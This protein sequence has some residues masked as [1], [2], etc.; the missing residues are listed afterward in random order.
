MNKKY[1]AYA[2]ISII[3]LVFLG[4]CS[5]RGV[6]MNEKLI[7][8]HVIAN[9]DSK[10]DQELKLK[11]R[12]AVLKEIGPKLESS[13]NKEES[14]KILNDNL[15]L[16]KDT[17]IQEIIKNGKSYPVSVT[18]GK[19][20]FP[21]KMYNDITL[22]PGEYDALKVVIG[23][24]EGA[25]WWCVMFPPLCFIDITRGITSEET[26]DRLK[27]VLNQQEYDSILNTSPIDNNVMAVKKPIEEQTSENP[28]MAEKQ[29]NRPEMKFKSAEA[30]KSL[31]DKIVSVMKK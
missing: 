30:A 17:A 14:K 22:P 19:S 12:D 5:W 28:E 11:V 4:S 1:Y 26:G 3:L 6:S 23:G 29:N 31:F 2:V 18:L 13:A 20:L 10:S 16:I 15:D 7:R 9:S 25:N 21:V 24:G 27:S 8:F